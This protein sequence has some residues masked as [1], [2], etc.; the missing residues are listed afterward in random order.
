MRDLHEEGGNR[1]QCSRRAPKMNRAPA[2]LRSRMIT[3][4]PCGGN[5]TPLAQFIVGIGVG[6]LGND[7]CANSRVPA[8]RDLHLK[9]FA[10]PV[11]ES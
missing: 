10:K 9:D 3:H 8:P 4:R 7:S 11:A 6:I 2:R 1:D 5:F